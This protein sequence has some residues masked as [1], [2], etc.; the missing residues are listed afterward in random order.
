V[1]NRL[2]VDTP[3]SISRD[4]HEKW[5]VLRNQIFLG[6][7]GSAASPR[8]EVSSFLDVCN[9]AGVRFVYFSP[10]NMRRTKGEVHSSLY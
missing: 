6:L 7:L 10:R 8:R 3:L 4:I 9:R 1:D 2:N 5:F